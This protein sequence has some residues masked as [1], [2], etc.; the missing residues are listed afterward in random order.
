MTHELDGGQ[1]G[2]G[3]F[4]ALGIFVFIQFGAHRESGGGGRCRNQLNHG[5]KA[6]ERLSAPIERNKGKQAV[7]NF[8]PLA[9]ARRQ[10]ANRDG[11][12]QLIRQPLQFD[13][14]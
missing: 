1:S 5:F 7:F 9:G 8:I 12:T 4:H 3:D 11:N 10:V 2:I 13:F 6:A 14:P